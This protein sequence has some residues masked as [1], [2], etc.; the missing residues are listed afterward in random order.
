MTGTAQ[1]VMH[2]LCYDALGYQMPSQTGPAALSAFL[3]RETAGAGG[4]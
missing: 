4:G 3:A 1:A 2:E